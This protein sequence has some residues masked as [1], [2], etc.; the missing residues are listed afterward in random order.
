MDGQNRESN[1]RTDYKAMPTP[2]LEEILRRD[3][4]ENL[5][6]VETICIVSRILRDRLEQ[7]RPEELPVIDL[8]WKSFREN[9][10]SLKARLRRFARRILPKFLIILAVLAAIA[11]IFWVENLPLI[12][13]GLTDTV[14]LEDG[15]FTVNGVRAGMTRA[16]VVAWLES[17]GL[18]YTESSADDLLNAQW[19]E[20]YNGRMRPEQLPVNLSW[21]S[22]QGNTRIEELGKITV[23]RTYYFTDGLLTHVEL[24]TNPV[25]G[26]IRDIVQRF[27]LLVLTAERAFGGPRDVLGSEWLPYDFS[28]PGVDQALWQGADGSSLELCGR[29][30]QQYVRGSGRKFGDGEFVDLFEICIRITL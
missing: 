2:T 12:T 30:W 11:V 25:Q 8:E 21:I 27:R 5:L 22:I 19:P 15:R 17:Q 13:E 18:P 29:C 9:Y 4:R 10:I 3:L 28:R 20:G 14:T 16:D 26:D 24:E 1:N 23:W 6:D 7:E